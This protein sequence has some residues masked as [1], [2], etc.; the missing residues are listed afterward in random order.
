MAEAALPFIC[1]SSCGRIIN[2]VGT[3]EP[4]DV[5][6]AGPAVAA[7]RLWSKALAR[8]VAESGTTVNSIGPGRVNSEQVERKF[9]PEMKREFSNREIPMRRFG[10]EREV[11]AVVAFLA[12]ARASYITGQ[13]IH[14]DGGLLRHP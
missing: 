10:E 8:D 6:V 7:T 14:V 2:F 13:T 4:L 9:T 1:E 3:F 5:H 11:A 12:S